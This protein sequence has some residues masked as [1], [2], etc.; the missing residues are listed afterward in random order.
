VPGD[1]RGVKSYHREVRRMRK[2]LVAFA[3]AALCVAFA[4]AANAA[5]Y[6]PG[7]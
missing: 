6:A 7:R 1:D 3:A 5:D 4:P 2:G